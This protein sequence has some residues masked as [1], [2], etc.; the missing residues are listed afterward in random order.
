MTCV[1]R[2]HLHSLGSDRRPTRHVSSLRLENNT[3]LL[4][5][6]QSKLDA[7]GA[8][9]VYCSLVIKLSK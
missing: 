1:G 9:N 7:C 6:N 4:F 2:V 8:E 5:T 3:W